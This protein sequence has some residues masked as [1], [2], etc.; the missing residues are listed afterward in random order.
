[1]TDAVLGIDVSKNTFDTN[2]GAGTKARSKSFANSPAGWHHLI[3]WLGEHKIGQVHACLEATGRHG[4]GIALALHEAG[5]VVS[6]VNPAQIRDFARTKLGRNKTDQVD[7]VHIRE[8]AELFKPRPWTPPSPAMRRLCELQ[9]I[10]AGTVAGL[11]EW[12]NRRGSGIMDDLALSLAKTTIQH[13]TSQLEEVDQ[14]IAETIDNDVELSAKRDLLV[15][16]NGVGEALAGIV[17]AELPGPDILGSSAAVTAYAGL[18]SAATP[19]WNL[20]QP[21]GADLQNWQCR[22]PHRLV[23]AGFVGDALQP[24]G[25]CFGRSAQGSGP[26]QGKADC[27]RCHAQASGALLRRAED[28]QGIRPG[29]GDR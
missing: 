12:K 5:H 25:R 13:F 28:R 6:I 4:L 18:K 22:A 26:P 11:T 29:D 9:T 1:M 19:V 20:G 21:A 16:I 7:A 27:D 10:R 23:H 2:L 8:Y 3:A 15:S 17:L 14:A 24:S